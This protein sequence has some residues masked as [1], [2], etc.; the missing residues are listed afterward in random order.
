MRL[1]VR[2]KKLLDELRNNGVIEEETFE[3]WKEADKV[4]IVILLASIHYDK[5]LML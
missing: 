5:K 1:K 3:S 4:S 2:E